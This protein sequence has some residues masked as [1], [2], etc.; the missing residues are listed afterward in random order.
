MTLQINAQ[1]NASD[2]MRSVGASAKDLI[3]GF[4]GVA[5]A[6]F[7]LYNAYDSVNDAQLR[8]EKANLSVAKSQEALNDAQDKASQKGKDL[9]NA[10]VALEQAIENYGEGSEEAAKAQAKLTKAT[11]DFSDACD[12][13]SLAQEALTLKQE[14]AAKAQ[15]D[16][17]KSMTSAFL[18]VV[19]SAITMVSSLSVAVGGMGTIGG[20]VLV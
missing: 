17:G 5:T 14:S 12:S 6:A 13:T 18:Q 15:E 7:G 3:V 8:V 9:E 2:T 16:V 4:S 19:P 20:I 11:E 1:D 10:Q